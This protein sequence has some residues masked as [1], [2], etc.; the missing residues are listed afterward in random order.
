MQ[1]LKLMW[2]RNFVPIFPLLLLLTIEIFGGNVFAQ[3]PIRKEFTVKIRITAGDTVLTATMYD[4]ATSRDFVA[5]MPLT[6]NLKDYA[7]TE[8]VSDLPKRLSTQGAPS[9]TDAAAGDITLYSPWG[10]LAIFY[11]SFGY[12]SGL[13][14]MGKVDGGLEGLRKLS[15]PARFE[16]ID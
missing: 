13:V 6:L 16:K 3:E 15:G 1:Q 8:K 10:N 11:K 9:G 2:R 14:T 4:N 5:L 7:S 12:A